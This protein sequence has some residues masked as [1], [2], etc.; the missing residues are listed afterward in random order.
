MNERQKQFA[1]EY[2]KTGKITESAIKAGY[3]ENYANAQAYKLL[4][5]V[6]IKTY[7]DNQLTN[8]S[9]KRIMQATEALELLTSIGRGE[10]TEEQYIGTQM[11]V[12]KVVKHPDIKDRQKAIESILKR[13]P[14]SKNE[15]LKDRMLELQIAKME[16]ELQEDKSTEDKMQE[17]FEK[18]DGEMNE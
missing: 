16:K 12:E 4:E 13:Y 14:F 2:I 9:N 11:G 1:D 8:M 5:N 6:G 3:S 17:F 10:M 18:L 7:I 15:E